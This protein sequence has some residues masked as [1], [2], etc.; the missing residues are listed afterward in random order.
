MPLQLTGPFNPF[1]PIIPFLE[2]PKI[3]LASTQKKTMVRKTRPTKPASDDHL[4]SLLKTQHLEILERFNGLHESLQILT[5]M[6]FH[7]RG[8]HSPTASAVAAKKMWLGYKKPPQ[9]WGKSFGPEGLDLNQRIAWIDGASVFRMASKFQHMGFHGANISMH[10]TL[11]FRPV[12][13]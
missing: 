1:V 8:S 9:R 6:S 11:G 10:S 13:S 4:L 2:A 7:D 5:R 12:D 3:R